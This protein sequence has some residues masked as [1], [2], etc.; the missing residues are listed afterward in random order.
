M[1]TTSISGTNKLAERIVS[2]AEAEARAAPAGFR[3]VQ[4]IDA[5][6]PGVVQIRRVTLRLSAGISGFAIEPDDPVS[7]AH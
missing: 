3:R 4:A 2:E 6:T 5:D 1:A 7:D